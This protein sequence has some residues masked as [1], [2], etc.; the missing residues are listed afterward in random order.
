[1]NDEQPTE[2]QDRRLL[3]A[4]VAGDRRAGEQLYDRYFDVVYRFFRSK[5][6][7]ATQ[8]LTQTTMEN[9]IKSGSN[10]QGT[11]SVRSFVLGIAV[12]VLRHHLRARGRDRLELDGEAASCEDL[13]LG[14]FELVAGNQDQKL[15]VKAL[16]RIPLEHQIVV[17]LHYWEGLNSREIGEALG[18]PASTIRDRRQRAKVLLRQRLGALMDGEQ[19]VES[20]LMGL[21]TWAADLRRK[22]RGG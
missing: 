16:R 6:P 22:I 10:F 7:E 4:W 1:M 21:R 18:V 11:G 12:N 17:E 9:L 8:D 15:L 19:R 13:G 5:I 2:Q 3:Q 20:T 14:P